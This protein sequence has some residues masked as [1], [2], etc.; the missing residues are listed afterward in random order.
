MK[1]Y[2][3]QKERLIET[4]TKNKKN[5][6]TKEQLE[7]KDVDE[8]KA[9]ATLAADNE[10][11][12]KKIENNFEG[13]ADVVENSDEDEEPMDIPTINFEEK[14]EEKKTA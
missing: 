9:L 2:N 13:Q 1:N 12:V 5:T 14:K 10:E 4:I 3:A 6:F 7:K 8:L 11:E